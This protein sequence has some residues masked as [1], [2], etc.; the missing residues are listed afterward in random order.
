[1]GKVAG[2]VKKHV[3]ELAYATREELALKPW[4]RLDPLVLAEHLAIPVWQL[5]DLRHADPTAADVFLVSQP[6]AFSAV[7]VFD[8]SARVIIHND[9]HALGRQASNICHELGHGLLLHQAT[10]ALDGSGCRT[11]DQVMEDQAQWMAG[12]L[13]V[14]EIGLITALRRGNSHEAIAAQFGV[15]QD[16]ISWRV[17]MTGALKRA[18][19]GVPRR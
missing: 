3:T 1:M 18:R 2:F 9:T 17:N 11:W 10:P 4:D 5:S 6:T 15:S 19:S 12:A 7:T 8:G 13:L 14:H 16:M